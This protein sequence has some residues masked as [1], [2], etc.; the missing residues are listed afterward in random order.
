MDEEQGDLLVGREV[1]VGEKA[2]GSRLRAGIRRFRRWAWRG[3]GEAAS[4]CLVLETV[5]V[6]P[7]ET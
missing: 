6:R 3:G 1:V 5:E 7:P 2:N 4:Y